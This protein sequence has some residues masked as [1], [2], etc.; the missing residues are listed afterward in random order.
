MH[1]NQLLQPGPVA[2]LLH[3]VEQAFPDG[4]VIRLQ[5]K[6][7]DE[8]LK[9]ALPLA[10]E[11]MRVSKIQMPTWN[12]WLELHRG[13]EMFRCLL[14]SIGSDQSRAQIAVRRCIPG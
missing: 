4:G 13:A 11:A 10:A 8:L 9:G 14:Q 3:F 2:N 7:G 5:L 1:C 6:R 12:L